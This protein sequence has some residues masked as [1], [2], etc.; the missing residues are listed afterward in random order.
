MITPDNRLKLLKE[1]LD[2]KGF[3]RIIEAHSG[4]SALVGD[5]ASFQSENGVVEY[6]GLWESSLTDSATKGLP[7]IEI[8][9]LDSR[10]NTINEIMEVSDKPLIVDGDT[11]RSPVEFEFLV[12][13][14]ERLGVSAVIIEDK[15]FPKRNSLD[16]SA[17]QTLEDP[18]AFGQK[19]Q[20][21]KVPDINR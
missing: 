12:R 15:V 16:T 11:G 13:R 4:L 8:I 7:D 1:K 19:I 6:D 18:V 3:V 21:G 5:A 9:S 14:L 20:R 10:I 17:K 2:Q